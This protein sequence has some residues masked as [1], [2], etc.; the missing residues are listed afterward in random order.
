MRAADGVGRD[1][2]IED[3][4]PGASDPKAGCW[5]RDLLADKGDQARGGNHDV[6]IRTALGRTLGPSP[7]RKRSTMTRRPPQRGQTGPAGGSATVAGSEVASRGACI[8][9]SRSRMRA[10]LAARVALASRP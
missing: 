10:M 9:A 5:S 3:E 4:R 1:D 7:G 6:S 8:G 2:P